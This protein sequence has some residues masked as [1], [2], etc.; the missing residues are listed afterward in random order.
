MSNPTTITS[1]QNALTQKRTE[2]GQRFAM[3]PNTLANMQSAVN[4]IPFLQGRRENYRDQYGEKIKELFNHDKQM[5]STF[6]PTSPDFIED[7]GAR[8]RHG[9]QILSN[10]GA[11][12][13]DIQKG[14]GNVSDKIGNALEMGMKLALFGIEADKY[15]LEGLENDRNFMQKQKEHEDN[16]NLKKEENQ[17]KN[18]DTSVIE[19]NGRKLL[20]DN[21]TGE[22]IKDLGPITSGPASLKEYLDALRAMPPLNPKKTITTQPKGGSKRPPLSS[23]DK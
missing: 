13:A 2:S 7:P 23:F 12:I 3:P 5:A 1:I 4:D 17:L 16:L 19:V 8:A 9:N 21:Q 15:A 6:Q 22:V 10:T 20:I 18:R 11:E 14:L